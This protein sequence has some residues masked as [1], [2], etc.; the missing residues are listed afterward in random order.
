MQL[1][2][3]GQPSQFNKLSLSKKNISDTCHHV[4]E[5]TDTSCLV[6][7]LY[8][9]PGVNQTRGV[10]I[11]PWTDPNSFQTGRG[12]WAFTPHYPIPD[13]LPAQ[14]RLIRMRLD[15][16]A[17]LY[18]RSDHDVYGWRFT[19][20]HLEEHLATLFAHELHHYRRYHLNLHLKKGEHGANRWALSHVQTLGYQVSGQRVSKKRQRKRLKLF[21]FSK[22]DPFKEFRH[23]RAGDRLIIKIDPRHIYINQT[24]QIVRPIRS[25]SKRI[26]IVTADGKQWRWPMTWLSPET[27]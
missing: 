2:I 14:F 22:Q 10:Y 7:A 11:R 3:F 6:T 18:P 24:V 17:N 16:R 9:I 1:F 25:N 23:L 12:K 4:A 27:K 5:S 20:Q 8:F 15:G 26:V 19:Y 13:N 21:G